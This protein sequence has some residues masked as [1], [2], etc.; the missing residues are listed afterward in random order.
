VNRVEIVFQ[1]GFAQYAGQDGEAVPTIYFT[2]A[3]D[4]F[5]TSKG[6]FIHPVLHT[7]VADQHLAE[8]EWHLQESLV[9]RWD[10]DDYVDEGT[11]VDQYTNTI[12]NAVA[13]ALGM[14]SRRSMGPVYPSYVPILYQP[15]TKE[16]IDDCLEHEPQMQFLWNRKH[17]K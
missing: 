2:R 7:F 12:F 10:E 3:G 6:A 15:M 5:E 9:A 11:N 16:E 1:Y 17:Q 8:S 13:T 4:Q 14:P